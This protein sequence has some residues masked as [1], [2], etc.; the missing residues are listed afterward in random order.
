VC[1]CVCSLRCDVG[2]I[3]VI[4]CTIIAPLS[5]WDYDSACVYLQISL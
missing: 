1:V 3:G 5:S 4:T 2:L